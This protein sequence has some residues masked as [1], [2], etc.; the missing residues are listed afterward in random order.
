[1]KPSKVTEAQFQRQVLALAK[2]TS[3]RVAHFRTAMN[4]RGQ[5]MTP[6]A[7]DGKGF[8]DLVLVK[9][10]RVLYRELKRDG[11]YLE[12][13]QKAW[14]DALLA[15]GADWALWRPRDWPLVEAT[16]KGEA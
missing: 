15:A 2:L 8:P 9:G 12:P 16:L 10:G 1:M 6:V 4:A 11:G 7:G 13:E 3:W 14:R 5:Y